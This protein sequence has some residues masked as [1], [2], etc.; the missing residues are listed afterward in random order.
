MKIGS[1]YFAYATAADPVGDELDATSSTYG[2]LAP[3]Q[4]ATQIFGPQKSRSYEFGTKWELFDRH[5]LVTAAP[6]Q[7]DV[8]NARETAPNGLPGYTSG[9]IVPGAAYRVRGVSTSRLPASSPANGA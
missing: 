4:N 2:G 3:T 9:Q 8:T 1:I 5:L 6:F 7:T